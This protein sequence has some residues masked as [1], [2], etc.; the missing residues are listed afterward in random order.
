M[1]NLSSAPPT[2][3]YR[4]TYRADELRLIAQQAQRGESLCFVGIAGAGKSNLVN[5]VRDEA[6][7]A[8]YLGT[9][10][11]QVHFAVVDANTWQKTP[12]SLWTLMATSLEAL[13]SQWPAPATEGAA[14]P[15]AE[16]ERALLRLRNRLRV[17]CQEQKRQVV[18]VLD[19]FDPAFKLG[20][21]AMLEQLNTLRSE[22]NR[23]RLSYLIF[24]KLL[25][26]V[27]GR[28]HQLETTSKFYD[29]FKHQIYALEPY[30]ASDARQML[31]FLNEGAGRPLAQKDLAA[32][33]GLAGGHSRL[34][35]LLFDLYSQE[36]GPTG[37]PE[38]YFAGKADV[39]QECERILAGLHEAERQAAIQVAKG[40]AADPDIV[41]HLARRG[42]IVNLNP[43]T[44]FSP[45]MLY[46]LRRK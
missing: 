18:F 8:T 6:R 23:N 4:P 17:V 40:G 26:H 42:L 30:A 12:L 22:G 25:P 7:M 46:Y 20:P 13:T 21:L 38:A 39:Q 35:K 29:L 27:L 16:E 15:F 44:W 19:D 33:H 5:S 14:I 41:D 37:N 43:P 11:S 1:S 31:T 10:A 28:Q 2:D 36:G 34:L 32:I 9:A 3:R 24:T 45:V